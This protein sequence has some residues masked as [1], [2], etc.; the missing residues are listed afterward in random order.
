MR[1]P[2]ADR[3]KPL[4]VTQSVCSWIPYPKANISAVWNRA[5]YLT[6]SWT[7]MEP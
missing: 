4:W 3:E 5:T 7:Q 2:E 6:H 1:Q